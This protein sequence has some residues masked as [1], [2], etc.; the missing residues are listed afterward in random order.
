MNLLPSWLLLSF[1]ALFFWGLWGFFPKIAT[2]YIDTKTY[3]LF[4]TV[5]GLIVVFTLF[6]FTGIDLQY[7]SIGLIAA[8]LSGF[9]AAIG[10]IFFYN[11]LKQGPISTVVVITALYPLVTILLAV[12]LFQETITFK[13]GFGIFLA[14]TALV[15]IST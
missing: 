9:S 10:S 4:S 14:L 8:L 15:F 6:V 1:A 3:L 13:Q 2:T 7:K 12:L 11:A 5:G